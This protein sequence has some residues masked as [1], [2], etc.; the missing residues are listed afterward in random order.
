MIDISLIAVLK[1]HGWKTHTKNTLLCWKKERLIEEIQAL[2]NNYACALE[3]NDN[4]YNLLQ[5]MDEENAKLKLQIIKSLE[6]ENKQLKQQNKKMQ[7]CGNC[8]DCF[9]NGAE[10]TYCVSKARS[11]EGFLYI[12]D[13]QLKE[14]CK[15]WRLA[16][17]ENCCSF[18]T[19]FLK[20]L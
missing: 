19:P 15:Y 11:N 18:I 3:M 7:R 16:E 5:K 2:E 10:E 8:Q 4:Q 17:T 9:W 12:D 13:F 1:K 6:E 14:G 20:K